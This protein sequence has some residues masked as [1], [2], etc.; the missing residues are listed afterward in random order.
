MP[1]VYLETTTY[2]LYSL[3]SRFKFPSLEWGEK[4]YYLA[5]LDSNMDL[6]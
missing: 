2:L 3:N 5:M 1:H 4:S 6:F